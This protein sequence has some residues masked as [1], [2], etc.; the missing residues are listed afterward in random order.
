RDKELNL[1]FLVFIGCY[2]FLVFVLAWKILS[3]PT[4]AAAEFR[5]AIADL[6]L[7]RGINAWLVEIK[8]RRERPSL[9]IRP[10]QVALMVG[11]LLFWLVIFWCLGAFKA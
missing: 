6:R 1:Y 4:Q 11:A 3:N 8:R 5:E 9:K 10:N 7:R 2:S